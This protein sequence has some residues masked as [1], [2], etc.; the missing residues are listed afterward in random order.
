MNIAGTPT[1]KPHAMGDRGGVLASRY[2]GTASVSFGVRRLTYAF[3]K[4]EQAVALP[5]AEML[6]EEYLLSAIWSG[7]LAH[8][9][10]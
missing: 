4:R 8:R 5:T 7:S 6:R 3:I 1:G 2:L 10:R 9:R